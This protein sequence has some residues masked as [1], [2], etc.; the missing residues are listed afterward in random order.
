MTFTLTENHIKLLQNL[1][2]DQHQDVEWGAPGACPKRPYGNSNM[3]RDVCEILGWEMPEYGTAHY[4]EVAGQATELHQ[5]LG[6]ALE[7]IMM[8]KSFETGTFVLHKTGW[9]KTA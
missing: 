5:D 2:W 3:P 1:Y 6:H 9:I 8:R 4:D 7:I